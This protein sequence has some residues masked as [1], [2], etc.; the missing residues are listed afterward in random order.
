MYDHS[1]LYSRIWSRGINVSFTFSNKPDSYVPL[2]PFEHWNGLLTILC[3][4]SMFCNLI[5]RCLGRCIKFKNVLYL[6]L[7]FSRST[8]P[9]NI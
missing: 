3:I 9:G 2:F 7:V 4:L 6:V 5:L 1:Q 8:L